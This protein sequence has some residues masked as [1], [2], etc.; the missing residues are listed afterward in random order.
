MV[1]VRQP[2]TS[3]LPGIAAAD[4]LA[5][6]L[7]DGTGGTCWTGANALCAFLEA[8]GFEARLVGSMGDRGVV[9]HGTVKV[10]LDGVDWLVDSFMQTFARGARQRGAIQQADR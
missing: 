9:T 3:P 5:T 1:A 6:W 4:F 7:A 10:S 2:G 8:I